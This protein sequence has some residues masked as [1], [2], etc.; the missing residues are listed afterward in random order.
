ML[1]D[2]LVL[3]LALW[4]AGAAALSDWRTGRIP[5]RLLLLG[6]LFGAEASVALGVW[7]LLGGPGQSGPMRLY[8]PL[9]YLG[10]LYLDGVIALG[11]G[12]VLWWIGVWAAGDAKLFA[13]LAFLLPL[14]AYRD[15]LLTGF[16]SFVL[17][18]NT[19]VCLMGFLLVEL[20]VKLVV[21]ALRP[22]GVAAAAA[23]LRRTAAG[24]TARGGLGLLRLTLGFVAMF[25]AIR[26]LRHLA[27]DALG[28]TIEL[29]H[30][31]VYVILF[32]LFAPLA[33]LFARRAVF[34]GAC[35]GVAL[36]AAWAFGLSD[37]PDARAA[38]VQVGWMSLSIVALGWLYESYT[39][40]AEVRRVP[41]GRVTPGQVLSAPFARALRENSRFN[42]ERMGALGP[43]G[44][45]PGQVETLR[46][47]YARH[48]PAGEEAL[49][50]LAT[51][52]PFAPAMLAAAVGT[53][54]AGGYL[55]TL[56]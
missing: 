33:R 37:D 12:L 40:F 16:P 26:V 41:V 2:W 34:V 32:V 14:G 18:F 36:Y 22:G 49:V 28:A 46:T 3:P 4:V 5:N 19:F 20:A 38:L 56:G 39:G 52:V 8:G 42:N 17:F 23:L 55:F 29:N 27:R 10:A 21:R 13:V 1:L 30:T 51:T 7:L 24:V 11:A 43:D 45:T 31:L 44:L 15:N 54:V 53:W 47:W 48:D 6:L 9:G 25:L 35:L 50:E